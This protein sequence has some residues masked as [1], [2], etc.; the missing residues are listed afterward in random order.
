MKFASEFCQSLRFQLE[1]LLSQLLVC[2]H[3]QQLINWYL[4]SCRTQCYVCV[5][6]CTLPD[7]HT[8]RTFWNL[9][10]ITMPAMGGIPF[11]SSY[12]ST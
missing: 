9:L 10:C 4:C 11:D 5:Y 12:I 7:Q 8:M 3:L 1:A 2:A 6:A